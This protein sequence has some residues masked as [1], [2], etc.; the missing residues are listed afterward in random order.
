MA[1]RTAN[2]ELM[3][4]LIRHQ[5]YLLRYS[6]YMRNQIT[7][8]LNKS[9]QDVANKIR[10]YV[11]PKDGMVKAESFKRLEALQSALAK[12]RLNAW[13]E[14][15]TF[16]DQQMQELE[17]QEPIL[18][19]K[20]VGTTLPVTVATVVPSAS[21]L[22][23]LVAVKPF[24]GRIMADWVATLAADD[25]RRMHNAV[26]LG[27]VAGEDMRKIA[28]RVVGS[29][30]L[31]GS[32]GTTE[33]TRRQVMAVTRT[34]VQHVANNARNLYFLEN[35]ELFKEEQFVATLDSRTTP[36]CRAQ[37]GK[38]YPV[39]KGP[40]PPLHYACRSLRVAVFNDKFL[41]SRPANPTTERILVEEYASENN[42]GK[43]SARD[44]LPR[45]TK[46]DYDAWARKKIREIVGPI[47][48][49][50]TYQI[51]LTQQSKMFQEDVLGIAKSKLFRDGKLPLDKFV[52]ANGE[53]LTLG[54]LARKHAEAFT[55][56]GLDPTKYF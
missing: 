5:V 39:G 15:Q 50:E 36:V 40:I 44:E 17:Y 18:L 23:G 35:R 43:I 47:P 31:K 4:A 41:G 6:G 55:A 16:F 53:E 8:L 45:G 1:R 30:T 37:D 48:A 9:E 10:N 34:A 22:R 13:G 25:V 12:I 24:E 52:D 33:L 29:A 7:A 14:V 56:A 49:A 28:Q 26:Q 3:D 2:E 51:W 11:P 19:D 46:G 54:Q 42:L 20:I 32:D 21:M 38:R 27:M